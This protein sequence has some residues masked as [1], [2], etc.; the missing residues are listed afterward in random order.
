MKNSKK[1]KYRLIQA[2]YMESLQQ[3]LDDYVN[4][5]WELHS[6]NISYSTQNIHQSL[7]VKKEI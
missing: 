1:L 4:A 7:I 2:F 3:E 6:D 5:G